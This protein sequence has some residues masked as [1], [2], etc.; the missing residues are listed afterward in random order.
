M[1]KI[2][3]NDHLYSIKPENGLSNTLSKPALLINN[4]QLGLYTSKNMVGKKTESKLKRPT[5]YLSLFSV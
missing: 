3:S 4:K 2:T 5:T 1:N